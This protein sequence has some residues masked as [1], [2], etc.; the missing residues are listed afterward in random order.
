MNHMSGFVFLE[1]RFGSVK[2]PRIHVRIAHK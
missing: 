2:V 1:Y